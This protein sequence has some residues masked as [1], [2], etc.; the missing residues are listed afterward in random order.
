MIKSDI[1]SS[2]HVSVKNI[3]ELSWNTR[4]PFRSDVNSSS[5]FTND[6]TF[7]ILM[8]GRYRRY[9]LFR[10]HCLLPALQPRYYL[11]SSFGI[12]CLSPVTPLHR[13]AISWSLV[14][15]MAPRL[16]SA[17]IKVLQ[18]RKENRQR[19]RSH[20]SLLAN[21]LTQLLITLLKGDLLY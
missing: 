11:L 15:P 19:S 8:E 20:I 16:V 17:M 2:R 4:S 14:Q 7:P 21:N 9:L 1:L 10:S 12:L 13:S 18:T 5:L 6:L 3:T